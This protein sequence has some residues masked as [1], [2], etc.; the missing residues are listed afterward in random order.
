MRDRGSSFIPLH[1]DIE[2]TIL[3]P[4]N[5]LGTLV[6]KSQ[7]TIGVWVQ[8]LFISKINYVWDDLMHGF[9]AMALLTC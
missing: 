2:K 7:L 1:E 9:S 4:L 5:D 8:K 6:K 3:S